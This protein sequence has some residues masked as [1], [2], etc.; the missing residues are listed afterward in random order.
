M[1]AELLKLLGLKDYVP[2]NVP[3]LL[4]GLGLPRNQ[5]QRLQETLEELERSGRIARIKGNRYILPQ[6]A[7]LIPGRLQVTRGGR[8]F[9]TPDDPGMKE[10][11]IPASETGTAMN[12]DH[13]LVR[14]DVRAKGKRLAS[15][16]KPSSGTVVRVLERRR[17]QM[18][19]TLKRGPNFLYVVP[20]DP[21]MQHDI[22]VPQPKDVGREAR[23]GD[24]VVV[25]IRHWESRH[26]SPE[27]EITEVLGPPTAE[28]VD[29][30]AVLRQYDLPL[31]FPKEVLQEVKQFGTQ[32]T[33]KDLAGRTDCR[34][35]PVITIDP[36][37][38]RDFDDAICLQRTDGNRWKL[39]VHIADVSHYVKPRTALDREARHRGNSTYLVDRVIPMLPEALS[40]ELCSLK[41]NVDRLTKCV[42]F[43]IDDQGKVLRSTFYE[44]VI[45]SKRRFSYE[46]AFAVLQGE[47][48]DDIERMVQDAGR[49]ALR[50]REKRF[51]NGSLDLDFP[52]SKIRLD[53][54]GRVA[55]IERVEND[56]SHQMI[57][58]FMLLAN[59]AVAGRLLNLKRGTIHRVHESPDPGRLADYRNDVLSHNVPCGNLEKPEEV[60]KLLKRLNG[61][62]IGSAL[63]IGFLKSLMRA[64]YSVESLGHYGLAKT[65]YA[66]FTSPIR[67]YADLVVHRSL[68]EKWGAKITELMK[69]AD[70]IS[71]TE[72]NSA[73]AEKDS[74][75]V[76]LYAYLEAQLASGKPVRYQALVI[77]IRNFGFFVD[78][79]DLG[80]SGLAPL[81]LIEDDFYEFDPTRIQIMGRRNRRIIRLGDR[82]EVEVAK[83]DSVKKQVDFRLISEDGRATSGSGRGPSGKKEQ[84]RYAKD[85]PA[86][87]RPSS[88]RKASEPSRNKKRPK[89]GADPKPAAAPSKKKRPS[90]RRRRSA[91][92]KPSGGQ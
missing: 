64:R 41:P 42:E 35:H 63:K 2:S 72:R 51:R 61:I 53:D 55:K 58:E 16:D 15:G 69:V 28:G 9:L 29:M 76:K 90:S 26:T 18:V 40:N 74:K 77:D 87:S 20:D 52:E 85:Q 34:N 62:A 38:A 66:H 24:K 81:S 70:H 13:V 14:L 6:E 10:I 75:A 44:S 30:L 17:S 86:K 56:L 7:D 36:A 88:K 32:V 39:W 59:E 84:R 23:V 83:V 80:M 25:E 5:Q 49:L 68:F 45:H 89:S 4:R 54:Q 27:G 73:D 21:R 78:V 22:L 11:P 82:V 1:E 19:G 60:Q 3:E 43:L 92:K 37:D 48:K 71:S 65:R 50:I 67:R 33:E 8:G 47:A 12:D 46:E 57:E 91:K 79:T 31:K